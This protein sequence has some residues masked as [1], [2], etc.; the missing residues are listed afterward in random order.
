MIYIDGFLIPVDAGRREAYTAFAEKAVPIFKDHGATRVVEGWGDDV[1]DGKIT[2]FRR[3][4]CRPPK[5]RRWYSRGSSGPTRR[6][7]MPA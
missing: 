5:A 3:S 7:A 6:P 2:D 4:V 1:P